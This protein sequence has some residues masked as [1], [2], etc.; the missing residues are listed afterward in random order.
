[1]TKLHKDPL[2]WQIG[3]QVLL[4]VLW[5]WYWWPVID[6]Q[7]WLLADGGRW[8]FTLFYDVVTGVHG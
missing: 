7:F 3:I 8:P 6:F 5:L 4:L 1:M 2:F